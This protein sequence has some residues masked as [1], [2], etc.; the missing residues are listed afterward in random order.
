MYLHLVFNKSAYRSLLYIDIS[1]YPANETGY[2]V[3]YWVSKKAGYPIQPYHGLTILH[4]FNSNFSLIKT[5]FF[6][7][8]SRHREAVC[9]AVTS[10]FSNGA[11][12]CQAF[13]QYRVIPL[14]SPLFS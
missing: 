5:I 2:P 4:F 8:G 7:D 3:E 12:S 10:L 6:S 9:S 1:G 13:I 11:R 14:Y